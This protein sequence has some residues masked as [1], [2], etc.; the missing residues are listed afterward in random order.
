MLRK[1]LLV[2]WL[3]ACAGVAYKFY[4]APGGGGIITVEG[5]RYMPLSDGGPWVSTQTDDAQ[6]ALSFVSR[7]GK[8]VA[9]PVH[10]CF[11]ESAELS[12]FKK[13][14]PVFSAEEYPVMWASDGVYE[15]VFSGHTGEILWSSRK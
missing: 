1:I 8:R 6:G 11:I 12:R 7:S 3:L 14:V 5:Q 9:L 2:S 13:D 4:Q 15:V 10:N